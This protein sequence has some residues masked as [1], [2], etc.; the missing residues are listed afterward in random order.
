MSRGD[1]SAVP[2]DKLTVISK[3][4]YCLSTRAK[5]G[6]FQPDGIDFVELH[7]AAENIW[8]KLITAITAVSTVGLVNSLTFSHIHHINL[9]QIQKHQIFCLNKYFLLQ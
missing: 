7:C 8:E 6:V 9:F 2:S 3:T 5:Q 1:Y 4:K